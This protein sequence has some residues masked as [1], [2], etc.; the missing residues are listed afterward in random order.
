MV[1]LHIFPY[2]RCHDEGSSNFSFGHI[3]SLVHKFGYAKVSYFEGVVV[4][5]EDVIRFDVSM[6]NFFLVYIFDSQEKLDEPFD[7]L[8]LGEG[9]VVSFAIL[10]VLLKIAFFGVLHDDAN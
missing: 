1:I 7:Y 3:E 6:D 9:L 4:G 2:L 10:E 8:L 5:N